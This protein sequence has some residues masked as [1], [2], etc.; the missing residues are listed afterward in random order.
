MNWERIRT[1]PPSNAACAVSARNDDEADGF[2]EQAVSDV[3]MDSFENAFSMISPETPLEKTVHDIERFFQEGIKEPWTA[4]KISP[5]VEWF[6]TNQQLLDLFVEAANR[7]KSY[8]P[9]PSLLEDKNEPLTEVLLPTIQTMRTAV[10][11]VTTR[12]LYRMAN[13]QH[14]D[15]WHDLLAGYRLADHLPSQLM[16]HGWSRMN[17]VLA[18]HGG[19]LHLLD[20]PH[21]P[22]DTTRYILREFQSQN[23][24]NFVADAIDKEDDTF[25]LTRR[26]ASHKAQ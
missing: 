17:C 4:E 13:G 10:K 22:A 9:S 15:A 20:Q 25:C 26:F 11:M 2:V 16:I 7:P 19:T 8:S 14:K 24:R 1:A 18:A 3:G 6:E 5:L 23:S 21:L 12:A